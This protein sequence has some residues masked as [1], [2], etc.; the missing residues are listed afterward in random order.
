MGHMQVYEPEKGRRAVSIQP[1][2]TDPVLNNGEFFD[3]LSAQCKNGSVL[4]CSMG[5]GEEVRNTNGLVSKHAYALLKI[6]D[7]HGERLM[8]LRNPWGNGEWKGSATAHQ[9]ALP[10][11]FYVKVSITIVK[12]LV[13]PSR[14]A[15]TASPATDSSIAFRPGRWSDHSGDWKKNP[16]MAKA[17]GWELRDKATMDDGIF[18]MSWNDFLKHFKKVGFCYRTTGHEG[19]LLRADLHQ[20]AKRLRKSP[21]QK[22]T[23]KEKVTTQFL[24]TLWAMRHRCQ[25]D[26]IGA[27]SAKLSGTI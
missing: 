10:F 5:G 7:K 25:V 2:K 6:V 24:P 9:A 22:T 14:R 12:Q 19:A 1:S 21:P 8:Q 11:K 26:A 13:G 15:K 23:K 18:W 3:L 4:E 20:G 27:T 16:K 17:C